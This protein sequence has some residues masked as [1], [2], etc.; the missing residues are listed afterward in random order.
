MNWI[1]DRSKQCYVFREGGPISRRRRGNNLLQ[2]Q[3][4]APQDNTYVAPKRA[5]LSMVLPSDTKQKNVDL[6]FSKIQTT[7][8]RSYNPDDI[9]Y[10]N[11]GLASVDPLQRSVILANII[12]E[13]G[14]DPFASG[15]GGFYGLLQWGS[16]RYTAKSSNRKQ[17]LDNQIQYI[18]STLHNTTDKMSQHHGGDGSGYNSAQ[19]AHDAFVSSNI[20]VDSVNWAYTL[21]YVRPKGKAQSARN[22]AKVAQQIYQII[23]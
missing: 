13:S 6:D 16:D 14:G 2:Q 7:G 3:I 12:E 17:E 10:I 20:P 18:L 21:G 9:A 15:P 8:G 4:I 19:A 11:Q 5:Y 22:R 1:Y 23:K